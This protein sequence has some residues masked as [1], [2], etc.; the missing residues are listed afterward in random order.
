MR[1]LQV[2]IF[3]LGILSFIAAAFFVGEP[4]GE[5]LWRVGVAAMLTAVAFTGL[6]PTTPRT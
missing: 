2:A 1:N 6:W 5:D 4:T 3:I